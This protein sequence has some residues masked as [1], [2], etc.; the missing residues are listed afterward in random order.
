MAKDGEVALL[1]QPYNEIEM[2]I[3]WGRQLDQVANAVIK[4][5]KPEIKYGPSTKIQRNRIVIMWTSPNMIMVVR[6][7]SR[8]QSLSEARAKD[9]RRRHHRSDWW[10]TLHFCLP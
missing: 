5:T 7:T 8:L 2:L 10:A 1:L 4:A 9:E 3:V 6:L